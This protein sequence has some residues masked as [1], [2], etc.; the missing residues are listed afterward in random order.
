MFV[1]LAMYSEIDVLN[2]LDTTPLD[3]ISSNRKA[4][5]NNTVCIGVCYQRFNNQNVSVE[6]ICS[7]HDIAE[8]LLKLTLRI[9]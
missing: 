2:H 6:E 7:Y 1:V 5:S 9:N 4:N 3:V 8:N